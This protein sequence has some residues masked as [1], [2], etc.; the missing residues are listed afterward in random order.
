ME[1]LKKVIRKPTFQAESYGGYMID[2]FQ[3]QKIF[4]IEEKSLRESFDNVNDFLVENGY[5]VLDFLHFKNELSIEQGHVTLSAHPYVNESDKR[6]VLTIKR[7]DPWSNPVDRVLMELIQFR[8]ERDWEQFHNSKDLALAL[9]IESSE[10]LELFLWKENEGANPNKLKEELADI[11]L[12][13]LLLLEKHGFDFEEI[14]M[15]KIKINGEKYPAS[16]SKGS[17]KKYNEL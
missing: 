1:K 3:F 12:Y 4:F 14:L 16:R 17:S 7:F 6:L 9:N 5:D 2:Q 11:F 8:N 15:E 13:G 10:L